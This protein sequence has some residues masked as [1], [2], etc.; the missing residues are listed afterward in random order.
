MGIFFWEGIEAVAPG[1]DDASAGGADGDVDV[2]AEE[3]VVV[4]GE[5]REI[6]GDVRDASAVEIELFVA[7]VIGGEKEDVEWCCHQS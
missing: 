7:E 2:A 5:L 6:G 1:G 3:G 4:G